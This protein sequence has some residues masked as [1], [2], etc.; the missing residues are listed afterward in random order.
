MMKEVIEVLERLKYKGNFISVL[1]NKGLWNEIVINTPDTVS[2]VERVY[3]YLNS[4]TAIY[5]DG[6]NLKK[7]L[8]LTRGYS[9]YCNVTNHCSR[10]DSNRLAAVKQGVIN[11]YGV[12]NIGKLPAAIESR[13]RFWSDPDAVLSAKE[14]RVKTNQEIYGC[15]NP[16]QSD[17]IKNRM[18]ETFMKNYGTDNPSKV[19]YI[20]TLKKETSRKNYG[21]DH[22]TQSEVVKR[23]RTE[24][25]IQRYGVEVPTQNEEVK[26]RVIATKISNGS[27]SRSNSSAE[28]TEYF[29]KYIDTKGYDITQV[30]FA[31]P[32]NGLHE[33]GYYFDRWYLYDF[34]AFS[35]GYRGDYTKIIE[36]IEYHGPFHYKE[37]DNLDKDSKA[38]PWKS[39]N[40]TISEAIEKDK[41][42]EEVAK[43]YLTENY[44]V[45]WSEKYHNRGKQ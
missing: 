36:I 15:D 41:K 40:T 43:K 32:D 2:D 9:V 33:W 44:T 12:D 29:R 3:L 34:V 21:V 6:G 5:C 1:K 38:Y 22:P 11:K 7:Y 25:N 17:T 14:K 10:C 20:K 39:N 23:R 16:A 42:K 26:K 4:N 18:K 28:A 35:P 31:D 13:E 8:G 19:E 27:F 24:T 37:S 45:V 30:A